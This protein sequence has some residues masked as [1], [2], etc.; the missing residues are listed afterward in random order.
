VID[1]TTE[2]VSE[3]PAVASAQDM[4]ALV[5]RL[6][7][8]LEDPR[9][10]ISNCV[11]DFVIDRLCEHDGRPERVEIPGFSEAAYPGKSSTGR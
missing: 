6:R 2:W 5:S 9:Q 8:V 4:F 10:L 7:F 1:R 11:A 3:L